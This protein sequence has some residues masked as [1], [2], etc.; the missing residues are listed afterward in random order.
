RLGTLD[1][2]GKVELLGPL[3]LNGGNVQ[4]GGGILTLLADVTATSASS[5][6]ASI[7]NSSSSGGVLLV[8]SSTAFAV[9]DGPAADDLTVSARI[10]GGAGQALVKDGAGQLTFTAANPYLGSTNLNAGV[11]RFTDANGLGGPTGDG[12][13]V[14]AGATLEVSIASEFGGASTVS[15]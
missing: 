7:A 12:A 13:T 15:E 4:L 3:A 2:G 14:A 8:N 11:L 9:G 6:G 5:S 10:S 1:L